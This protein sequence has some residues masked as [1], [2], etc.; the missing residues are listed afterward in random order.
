MSQT[1]FY[2]TGRRKTAVARV[3]LRPGTGRIQVNGKTVSEYFNR[4]DHR[5]AAVQPLSLLEVGEKFDVYATVKGGGITGQAEAMRHGV[6]LALVNY[7]ED[8]STDS[9]GAL[10][11]RQQ[12]RRAGFVTRDAR[13]VERK[14]LGRRKARKSEQYSKR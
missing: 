1:Q 11:Y 3:F 6:A 10:G 13:K 8:G 14:K 9:E 4:G 12:L 7:D 2:G 5:V